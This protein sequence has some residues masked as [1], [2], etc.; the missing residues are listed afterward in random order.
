MAHAI[1]FPHR[2]L[3]ESPWFWLPL[4]LNVEGRESTIPNLLIAGAAGS[5]KSHGMRMDFYQDCRTIRGFRG[6]MMRCSYDELYKNHLQWMPAE[7]AALGEGWKFAGGGGG[8]PK[9]MSFAPMDAVIFMGYCEHEADIPRHLGA[10]HDKI[11]FEEMTT[12]LP[13]AI[14]E[15]TPRA[16][17]AASS[18]VFREANGL[19]AGRTVGASNPGGRAML[20]C[21]DHYIARKVDADD[22]PHYDPSLYG[23]IAATLDDNPYLDPDY[24]KRNL[25]GL[26]KARYQQLRHGDWNVFA[27][28]FFDAYDPTVHVVSAA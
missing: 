2:D 8:Q 7:A 21:Y 3:Q 19:P 12:F 5:A 16:R 28:Q 4:P 17:G 13:R 1:P 24:E 22:Y 25:S 11:G 10:E 20:Y 6:L 26:S 9:Q 18:R 23:H 27:G 15:I 14:N